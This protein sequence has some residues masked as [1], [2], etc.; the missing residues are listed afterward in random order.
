MPHFS[1]NR[2]PLLRRSHPQRNE[3]KAQHET[4][5]TE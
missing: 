5:L 1:Y 2:I 3:S 4:E